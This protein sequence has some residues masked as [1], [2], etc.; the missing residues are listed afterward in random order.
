MIRTKIKQMKPDPTAILTA[1][2]HLRETIPLCRTDDF[3]KAQW[4]KVKQVRHLQETY[5]CPVLHSGDLF[6]HWKPSPHLLAQTMMA[7]PQNFWTVYGNHDLPQHNLDLMEKCGL[8]V[9]ELSGH[10]I[11]TQG[12]HW[13][14][15]L[16]KDVYFHPERMIALW[17]VMT[18]KGT[19][20]WP[21]CTDLD[22][23]TIL[24]N[25]PSYD[26][27]ITGHNHKSFIEKI[28]H[29][30]L[31]N[32]GSLTR[33]TAD[34]ID[35]RPCVWFYYA[36]D[37]EV[38]PYYLYAPANV[39][40]REHIIKVEERNARIDAFVASLESEAFNVE[41]AFDFT[42]NLERFAKANNI[43]Q[44]VMEIVRRAIE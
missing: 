33:Q 34:Q 41:D 16:T 26:L 9:L 19:A 28:D 8:Y 20:P 29:R 32:P 2:W 18:Y 31:C 40:S 42:G 39:V 23:L 15:S 10:V 24:E 22:A 11:V 30:I 25:N 44:S 13:G 27:I 17:H 36:D 3:F 37:N 35:H 6:H 21:G 5:K 1:D 14:Q 4:E 38:V 43:R 7:L 12:N